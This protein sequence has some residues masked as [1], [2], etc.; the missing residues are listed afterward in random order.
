ML[1]LLPTW[2]VEFC[3]SAVA[4]P[5]TRMRERCMILKIIEYMNERGVQNERRA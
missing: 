3:A 2:E 4:A 1:Q 5:Q